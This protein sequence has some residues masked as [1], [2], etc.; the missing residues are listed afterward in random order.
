[1]VGLPPME[2][3]EA[4]RRAGIFLVFPTGLGMKMVS[5]G[6]LLVGH[7]LLSTSTAIR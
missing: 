5:C 6:C 4:P 1:M 3:S 2:E 7:P